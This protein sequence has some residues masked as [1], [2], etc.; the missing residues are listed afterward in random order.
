MVSGSI[1]KGGLFK[2]KFDSCGVCRLRIKANSILV[3]SVVAES[4]VDVLV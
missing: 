3:Y 1:A 4:T 2:S